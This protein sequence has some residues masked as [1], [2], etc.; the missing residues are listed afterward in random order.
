MSRVRP[1]NRLLWARDDPASMTMMRNR[2]LFVSAL[3][4][5]LF[6]ALPAWA[7]D[8]DLTPLGPDTPKSVVCGEVGFTLE[9]GGSLRFPGWHFRSQGPEG[10]EG[11]YIICGQ[12]LSPEGEPVGWICASETYTPVG[13]ASA[14]H[15]CG[16]VERLLS[17]EK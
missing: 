14:M 6:L 3:V 1:G 13:V 12:F 5:S 9:P 10:P 2:I 8:H 4:L 11:S 16:A 7:Q 17:G 15:M